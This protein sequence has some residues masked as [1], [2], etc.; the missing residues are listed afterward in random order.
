LPTSDN[1]AFPT[2]SENE[3]MKTK[4]KKTVHCQICGAKAVKRI[5]T[6]LVVNLC[7][8]CFGEVSR[9]FREHGL[10]V[11]NV[12]AGTSNA[13]VQGLTL[14][15][16]FEKYGCQAAISWMA[17]NKTEYD[18]GVTLGMIG[19]WPSFEHY[20]ASLTETLSQFPSVFLVDATPDEIRCCPGTVR[21]SEH[22]S[23]TP[24]GI[25]AHATKGMGS[26]LP[27]ITHSTTTTCRPVAINP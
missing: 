13:T 17:R 18:R 10:T 4:S 27:G 26:S 22:A 1:L 23:R 20:E 24:A 25:S 19:G 7:Q 21:S 9:G 14:A 8:E 3:T 6:P 5:R 16:E 11:M 12:A 15:K 2:L